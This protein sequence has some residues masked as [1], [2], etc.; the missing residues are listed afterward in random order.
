MRSVVAPRFLTRPQWVSS[1]GQEAVEL[2]ASAGLFLDGWQAHDLDVILAE[3]DDGKWAARTT[4]VIVPRQNGKG[5]EIEALELAGLFLFGE[6]VIM[7]SAHEFKTSSEAFLRIKALI[8]N[9]DDLRRRVKRIHS[10]HGSEGIELMT[11]QRLR[12]VAR[13]KGSGRG[14]SGDRLILDEAF[15]LSAQ[16]ISAMVPTMG[17]RENPQA[18]FFS[19]AP[20]L[21]PC[22]DV[23][24][25][26]ILS[27]RAGA[28]SLALIEYAAAPD[29]DLDDRGAWAEANPAYPHRLTDDAIRTERTLMADED[30]ARE[31]CGLWPEGADGGQ[32]I[33]ALMWAGCLK[34]GSQIEGQQTFALEVAEDRS[35]S[36]IAAAGF[37]T[38]P[39]RLHGE[40]VEYRPGTGWIVERVTELFMRWGGQIA[41]AKSSPA[42][43]M[44]PQLEQAG[45]QVLEVSPEQHAR[46]CGRFYDLVVNDEFAHLG[47]GELE[48]A[49]R[50]AARKDM[51]DAWVWSRRRSTIDIAP[52]VAV[53]LAVGAITPPTDIENEIW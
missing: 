14:F 22:S 33:P 21:D 4:G 32:V 24:R 40:V 52:L 53:T 51:G 30:F 31:R 36:A 15:N 46:S 44:I 39:N 10:A 6:Q 28:E 42:A 9:T 11:G 27:G 25:E 37:S 3:R 38:I 50:S 13:S 48:M 41:V 49:V 5:S 47:S 35:W 43:A 12:F 29:A 8:D 17:A 7:H 1:S 34:A 18:N 45:V 16:M 23:L 2:A 26:F 20:I 19:S